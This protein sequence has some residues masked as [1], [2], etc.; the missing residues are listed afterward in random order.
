MA[1]TK[2]LT[3]TEELKEWALDLSVVRKKVEKSYK[4]NPTKHK[5]DLLTSLEFAERCVQ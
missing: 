4:T 5:Y 1:R 2:R 3:P